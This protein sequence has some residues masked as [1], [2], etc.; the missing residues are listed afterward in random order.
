MYPIYYYIGKEKKRQ[1][2]PLTFP[3]QHQVR[4]LG[5]EYLIESRPITG[6]SYENDTQ[7]LKNKTAIITKGDSGIGRSIAYAFAREGADVVIVCLNEHSDASETKRYIEEIDRTCISIA[8][9]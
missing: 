2:V 3:P 5:F 8:G 9:D 1:E 7:K 4:Q 6:K